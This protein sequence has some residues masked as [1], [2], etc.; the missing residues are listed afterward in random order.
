MSPLLVF[1]RMGSTT[2]HI[3]TETCS[4]LPPASITFQSPDNFASLYSNLHSLATR[5]M[6]IFAIFPKNYHAA[7]QGLKFG[8]YPSSYK[9]P[10]MATGVDALPTVEDL[11]PVELPAVTGSR[12]FEKILL[13]QTPL[14][15]ISSSTND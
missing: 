15:L 8:I 14:S 2:F 6:A 7:K 11:L 4:I 1:S 9:R 10:L 12:T 3:C 5:L 13:S